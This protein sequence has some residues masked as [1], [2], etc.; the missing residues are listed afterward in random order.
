MPLLRNTDF[1][2][3]EWEEAYGA[4]VFG[5]RLIHTN[6]IKE[7][8][9][10]A[11]RAW[12]SPPREA[13]SFTPPT[14]TSPP[15]QHSACRPL[16]HTCAHPHPRLHPR[17]P[18]STPARAHAPPA[19]TRVRTGPHRTRPPVTEQTHASGVCH[20]RGFLTD[21][22]AVRCQLAWVTSFSWTQQQYILK[23]WL[24]DWKFILQIRAK[25]DTPCAS[26]RLKP[27]QLCNFHL[28]CAEPF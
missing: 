6:S 4:Q 27:C 7:I 22:S 12:P 11:S 3:G 24:C 5:S 25:T 18:A 20:Q 13:H 9:R 2:T 15:D 14:G 17:T 21:D 19:Q 26:R 8:T 1:D 16:Q 10:Q 23:A 28:S